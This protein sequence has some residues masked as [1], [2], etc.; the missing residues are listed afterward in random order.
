MTGLAPR[1]LSHDRTHRP[2]AV[3]PNGASR[4][5]A[6]LGVWGYLGKD[7]E[8]NIIGGQGVA[9]VRSALDSDSI[10]DPAERRCAL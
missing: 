5:R 3:A 10:A 7:R 4:R 8:A 1:T 6:R 9:L 2:N